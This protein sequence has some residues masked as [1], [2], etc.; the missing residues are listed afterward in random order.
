MCRLLLK[1]GP[2]VLLKLGACNIALSAHECSKSKRVTLIQVK[3]GIRGSL[4][5]M[6]RD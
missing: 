5:T 3:S 2:L 1:S 4:L 6:I